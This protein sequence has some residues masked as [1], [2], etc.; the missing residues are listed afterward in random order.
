MQYDY[1]TMTIDDAR[2]IKKALARNK[3]SQEWLIHRLDR[4]WG[5]QIN[6]AALSAVLA[7]KR[8]IGRR[9]QRML[10]CS[11]QIIKKYEDFYREG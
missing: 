11:D 5:I 9:M 1:E 3:L 7:G 4:D 6:Y 2:R 10:W 8:T